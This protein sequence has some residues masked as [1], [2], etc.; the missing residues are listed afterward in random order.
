MPPVRLASRALQNETLGAIEVDLGEGLR[1]DAVRVNEGVAVLTLNGL[2]SFQSSLRLIAELEQ[3]GGANTAVRDFVIDYAGVY[4]R[5]TTAETMMSLSVLTRT[6]GLIGRRVVMVG[7]SPSFEKTSRRALAMGA[8][9]GVLVDIA[10]SIPAAL[11]L[12]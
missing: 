5:R 4:D 10:S 7:R 9:F 6:P 11:A 12:L 8:T 1:I 3:L 2:V